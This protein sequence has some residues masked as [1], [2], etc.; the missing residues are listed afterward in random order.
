M[1]AATPHKTTGEVLARF[2]RLGLYVTPTMIEDDTRAHYLPNRDTVF[3]GRA[4]ASGLWEPVDGA[5]R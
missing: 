2:R 3:R 1:T 4:G 5:T